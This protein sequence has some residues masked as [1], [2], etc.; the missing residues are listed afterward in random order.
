MKSKDFKG[1]VVAKFASISKRHEAVTALRAASLKHE[2]KQVWAK[3]DL[4]IHINAR[5]SFLNSLRYQLVQWGFV[6]NE[7]VIDAGYTTLSV[8]PKVVVIVSIKEGVMKYDWC[9]QWSAWQ[10]LQTS[11]E[12][13]VLVTKATAD[14]AKAAK[15]KGNSKYFTA[16]AAVATAAMPEQD[17]WAAAAGKGSK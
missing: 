10:E 6:Y 16:A 4:P 9:E 13:Q 7:M 1:V 8:G 14:L 5:K 2:S 12:L 15:G 11:P 17:P 3:E